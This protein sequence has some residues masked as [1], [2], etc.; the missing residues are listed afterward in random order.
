MKI[1]WF[2]WRSLKTRVTMMTL[3]IVLLGMVSL[4]WYVSSMLREDLESLQGNQQFSMVTLVAADMD[5]EI[6]RHLAALQFAAATLTPA[7]IANPVALGQHLT[8]RQDL[9]SRF[10]NGIAVYQPD[11]SAITAIPSAS[12]SPNHSDV[13][14]E[15]LIDVFKGAKAVVGQPHLSWPNRFA[16]FVMSVPVLDPAGQVIGALS[17][18]TDLSG[19][20]FLDKYVGNS[21][22][23]SGSFVLIAPRSR[24]VV[25]A[26]DKRRV[27]EQL[28]MPGINPEMDR[29]L[30]GFE[31]F[32]V[33]VGANGQQVLAAAKG[34]PTAG[35][36]L[37]V[38]LPTAE[39]FAP[40]VRLQTRT[41][42]ATLLFTLVAGT[43]IWWLL[44]RELSPMVSAVQTLA[45]LAD[46]DQAPQPLPIARQD[47][48]GK[49][50]GSFNRLL[51]T[52]KHRELFLQQILDTSSV[53]IYLIDAEGRINHVNRRMS[54]MFGCSA[55][56]LNGRDYVS[57]L[58]PSL[59]DAGYKNMQALLANTINSSEVDRIYCRADQSEFWGHLTCRSFD[60]ASGKGRFIVCV[61]ND[62]TEGKKVHTA[63]KESE[64]RYSTLIEWSPD[65]A[66]VHRDGVLVYAN[67]AAIALFGANAMSDLVGR[68]L[69]DLVAPEAQA[70]VRQR[71]QRQNEQGG[72]LPRAETRFVKLDGSII[73]VE[74]QAT[75]IIYDGQRTNY[76]IIR[77][78]TA[79]KRT[80]A[81]LS[82]AATAFESQQGITITNAQGTILRTNQAFTRITG[83][84][85][86]EALGQNPRLLASGR[87]DAVFYQMMWK[88]LTIKGNW[89]GEIWN[90]RKDGEIYPEWLSISAVKDSAGQ[91]G[92]YVATFFDISARKSAEEQINNLAFYDPLTQLPNRRLLLDR[93]A[94]ALITCSRHRSC[95]AL[96]FV[97]L[98]NFKT[99]NETLGH[100][101]GDML[102]ESVARRLSACVRE[103][104]TVA[105]LGGDEFV[106]MIEHLSDNAVDA[107]TQSE[108]VAE[109]I[110]LSLNRSYTIGSY[111]HHSTPSIGI[112]LFGEAPHE[113]IDEPLKRAELAMY[114]AKAAGRN[115]LRFFDAQMQVVVTQRAAL[116]S[117]LSEALLQDQLLLHYQAQVVGDGRLTGAEVLVRWR[118]PERGLVSPAE[119]IPLA[120]ETGLIL[121]LG[122]W[123][124]ETACRQLVTWS[125]RPDLAHLTLAV[126]VS[127]K[128]FH[129]PD[130]VARV[131]SVLVRT[132]V[133]PKRLKLELTESLMI[134]D[135]E[136]II[137]KMTSL[138]ASG[139]GFS[140]DDFGTGYSSLSYLKRLPLDQL[141]I[142][143]GFVRNILT[144]PNDA[145]IAKMVV[146]LAESM[147]LSVIAE[148]VE[149]EAQKDFLAHLG[150]HAYQGYLYSR[151]LALAEFERF[152]Q[153]A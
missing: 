33:A 144:D 85:A 134:N 49:L 37:A 108:A 64:N 121:P 141:K 96:L 86:E 20:N 32:S 50:I 71:M 9:V 152:T 43:L 65:A 17:G 22:G 113:T 95:G 102:L 35:W 136:G 68:N 18:A 34:V 120:E 137:T 142:D 107:A 54:D 126:N 92:H 8:Q 63:L 94:Q 75:P 10:N 14:R 69:I 13:V 26:T 67:G 27:L 80:Q 59:Q 97:D 81:E 21:Y 123:V 74:V 130:F 83:Y 111:E 110:R 105:R 73:D 38:L 62:I 93:L 124:L 146:A 56:A 122:Q 48:I 148:G 2:C 41:L 60:D 30:L 101:Q 135:V 128:Q 12:G 53:A 39:A 98:D 133:N 6:A 132:G 103:G 61:I 1:Y 99:L 117:D 76:S 143:Q 145:A 153:Q 109:K 139:V 131:Q 5:R 84:S 42:L 77:D 100:F 45:N 66:L 3:G 138:K 129:Q 58:H 118:H 125:A 119:F 15:D 115:A 25:T 88:S 104:D 149:I 31:G 90:R 7:L 47:E 78:I 29:L 11:G 91:V 46:S 19:V 114:Q 40:F 151:P 24:L 112:T 51:A 16:A 140:L 57:L 52:L 106:V 79:I 116:E 44:K 147:G 4:A 150:C 89:Q 55:E 72:S 36:Q 87:H 127:A 70:F 82:I 23:A 28:P